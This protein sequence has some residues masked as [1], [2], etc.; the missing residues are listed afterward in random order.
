MEELT[1]DKEQPTKEATFEEENQRL[2]QLVRDYRTYLERI[3]PYS[4][5]RG[6]MAREL[7]TRTQELLGEEATRDGL[8]DA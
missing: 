4:Y 7:R 2:R 3:A 8:P 5:Y 6:A 1:A